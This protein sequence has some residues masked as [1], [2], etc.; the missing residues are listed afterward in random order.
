MLNGMSPL[1]VSGIDRLMLGMDDLRKDMSRVGSDVEV[2]KSQMKTIS[3]R[4][5]HIENRLNSIEDK[6]SPP[7]NWQTWTMLLIGLVM[8]LMVFL[9][10]VRLNG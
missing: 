9:L 10:L 3:D 4:Q 7:P 1:G 8:S 2:L 5:E 6:L